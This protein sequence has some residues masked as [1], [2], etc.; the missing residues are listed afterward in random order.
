[1]TEA[2]LS[3]Q[4][5]T[6]PEPMEPTFAD[7]LQARRVLADYLPRTPLH[8]HPSLDKLLDAQ[9]YVKH[10]NYQPIGAFKVRGGINFLAHLPQDQRD[11]GV[12][13]ASTGNHGQ[14]IAY[15]AQLFGIRAVIIVPEN[16][17]PVKVEAMQTLGADVRLVGEDFEAA[18]KNGARI[19][20]EEGLRW[21]SSGDEPLLIAGVA[22]HTLEILEDQPDVE[23]IFVPI[24]G[25][26]GAAGASLVAKSIN[27]AI[28]VIG[29][30]ASAS[31]AAYLTWRAHAYQESE[32][33][34]F[35]EGL[36]TGAPFMMPQ[37]M[38]WQRLD[39]FLLVNDDAMRQAVRLY[40]EK[41]KTLA[42]P[43]GAAPLAAALQIKD[44]L[45]G[46]KVALILSGG[47]VSP[48]Q[49]RLCLE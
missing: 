24:G 46:R 28:R 20:A 3:P 1:V 19:A 21:V 44:Q 8:H 16:A 30:Q 18:K 34:T 11:L 27:P 29:V 10:E 13:T 42:E 2:M 23:V 35:A 47:N 9:V 39:D 43:A 37:R 26:S 40:L 49:L 15:A 41:V 38:L 45:A 36:A 31:P 48:Q 4:T 33:R 14:S 25:G 17:N 6:Q 12:A 32:N 5:Q 22:T 7:V